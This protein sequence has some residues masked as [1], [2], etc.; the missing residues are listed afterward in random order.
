MISPTGKAEVVLWKSG[1][2]DST[3]EKTYPILSQG[4]WSDIYEDFIPQKKQNIF[5]E[6]K[7]SKLHLTTIQLSRKD[8]NILK[9]INSGKCKKGISYS[10]QS[11]GVSQLAILPR[12]VGEIYC[13]APASK[14]HRPGPLAPENPELLAEEGNNGCIQHTPS[15]PHRY[16]SWPI[17]LDLKFEW[18]SAAEPCDKAGAGS[19]IAKL[20]LALQID[21]QFRKAFSLD[22][23]KDSALVLLHQQEP[24]IKSDLECSTQP[25]LQSQLWMSEN[26]SKVELPHLYLNPSQAPVNWRNSFHNAVD[27]Y[28]LKRDR[29]WIGGQGRPLWNKLPVTKGGVWHWPS[30][31]ASLYLT[32]QHWCQNG[33]LG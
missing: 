24:F 29:R 15:P 5:T 8:F 25:F 14:W 30:Q 9:K 26:R 22:L 11:L 20:M 32:R 17:F 1:C 12:D 28:Q 31:L 19:A 3:Q 10:L 18:F 4:P 27:V 33:T 2:S 13:G 23:R 21:H 16:Q 6:M 7:M